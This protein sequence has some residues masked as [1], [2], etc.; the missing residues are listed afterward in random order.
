MSFRDTQL[1]SCETKQLFVCRPVSVARRSFLL[2]F[3]S[4]V[5]VIGAADVPCT[6]CEPT[7]PPVRPRVCE[8]AR[9]NCVITSVWPSEAYNAL[10]LRTSQI[11][12]CSFLVSSHS[13]S[14]FFFLFI[15]I[16]SFSSHLHCYTRALTH[17]LTHAS[18]LISVLLLVSAVTSSAQWAPSKCNRS[19][20]GQLAIAPSA[21]CDRMLAVRP[22]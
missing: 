15:F 2:F 9:A 5:V 22:V 14:L 16:L 7:P 17:T 19:D 3:F 12:Q 10:A 11:K 20:S 18:R 1:E 8:W 4:S 21:A 6:E 13:S